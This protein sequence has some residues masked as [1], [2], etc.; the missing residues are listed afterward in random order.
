MIQS[1]HF[2]VFTKE[3]E[4]TNCKDICTLMFITVLFTITKIEKQPKC[5]LMGAQTKKT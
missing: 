2:L 4:S 5:P 1:F 3:Y